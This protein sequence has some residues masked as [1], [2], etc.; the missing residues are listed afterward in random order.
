MTRGDSIRLA[1][2]ARHSH[3]AAVMI[4]SLLKRK[5]S[6]ESSAP[7]PARRLLHGAA[8]AAQPSPAASSGALSD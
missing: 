2:S 8:V 3:S 5:A 6:A 7:M 1:S 4:K